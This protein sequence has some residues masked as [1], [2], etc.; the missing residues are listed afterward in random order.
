[1]SFPSRNFQIVKVIVSDLK[2]CLVLSRKYF[3][4]KMGNA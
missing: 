3:S 1:M 4:I 2:K